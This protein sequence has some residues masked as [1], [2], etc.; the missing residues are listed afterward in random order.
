MKMSEKCCTYA[1]MNKVIKITLLNFAF[2]IVF[3]LFVVV[4]L[5]LLLLLIIMMISSHPQGGTHRV[6]LLSI[7]NGGWAILEL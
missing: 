7:T 5:V 3:S 4:G 1:E 6:F 2:L